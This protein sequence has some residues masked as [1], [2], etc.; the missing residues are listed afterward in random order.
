MFTLIVSMLCSSWWRIYMESHGEKGT[1]RHGGVEGALYGNVRLCSRV[2][3]SKY[4]IC[5]EGE[6]ESERFDHC[7]VFFYAY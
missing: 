7:K 2:V 3:L 5:E 1:E 6:K 4:T